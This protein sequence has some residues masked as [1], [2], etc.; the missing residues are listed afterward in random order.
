VSPD[1]TRFVM[2]KSD[3]ASSLRQL[4]VLQNEFEELTRA[5]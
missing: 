4:T 3:E 2:V 5:P 1:G